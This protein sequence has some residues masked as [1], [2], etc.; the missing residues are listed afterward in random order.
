MDPKPGTIDP[1]SQKVAPGKDNRSTLIEKINAFSR[2]VRNTSRCFFRLADG[3]V[4][5]DLKIKFAMHLAMDAC[6]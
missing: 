5:P 2:I 1:T 3:W 4:T 6:I